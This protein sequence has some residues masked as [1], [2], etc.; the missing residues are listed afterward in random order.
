MTTQRRLNLDTVKTFLISRG[1]TLV[2]GNEKF[3]KYRPPADL[4]VGPE[5]FLTLPR[6]SSAPDINIFMQR[7]SDSI[8]EL[9]EISTD[10]L[11]TIFSAPDT[12]LSMQI[13]GNTTIDGS[14]PFLSFEGMV[15]KLKKT[16]IDVA[17]FAATEEPIIKK[18]PDESI[19]YIN[20]CRFLQTEIGSFVAKIQL[21][22]E[23]VLRQPTLFDNT[24]L[25]SQQV[26]ERLYKVLEFVLGPIFD[27][28]KTIYNDTFIEENIEL[29]N[30]NVFEDIRDLLNRAEPEQINFSFLTAKKSNTI[31]SG[32][33]T[34]EKKNNLLSYI[35][36]VKKNLTDNIQVETVGK[37]VELRSKNPESNL[38]Y[39]LILAKIENNRTYIAITMDNDLYKIAIQAHR[40]NKKVKIK[41]TA[42][43]MKTQLKI[44]NLEHFAEI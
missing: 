30:L 4:G 10:N 44:V 41:G 19:K 9:Y 42:R 21:P 6:T 13:I 34:Q 37:I 27:N 11:Y 16:L 24:G 32:E 18:V 20:A 14:I 33:I 1:W 29:V 36:Y 43:K 35:D 28:E 39:I 12:V 23:L 22:S 26:N 5:F 38:N 40:N 2:S 15:E 17:A 8:S 25:I 3:E 7:L 31:E